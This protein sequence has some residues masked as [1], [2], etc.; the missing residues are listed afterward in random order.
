MSK[1]LLNFGIAGIIGRLRAFL[2]AFRRTERA[3][4]TVACDRNE[5]AMEEAVQGLTGIKC[6]RNYEEVYVPEIRR[7]DMRTHLAGM[8]ARRDYNDRVYRC[9]A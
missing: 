6:L 4:R 7:A 8:P 2:D 9:A 1:N 3:R 5:L